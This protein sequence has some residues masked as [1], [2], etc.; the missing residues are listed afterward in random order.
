VTTTPDAGITG[1]LILAVVTTASSA[2]M[3][4]LTAISS[5]PGTRRKLS[6]R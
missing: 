6:Q 4:V 1:I 2:R 3:T 5:W